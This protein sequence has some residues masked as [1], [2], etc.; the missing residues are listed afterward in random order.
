MGSDL[1]GDVFGDGFPCQ[2]EAPVGIATNEKRTAIMKTQV[3]NPLNRD[4]RSIGRIL[5]RNRDD[6]Q[7]SARQSA[8][9]SSSSHTSVPRGTSCFVR[10]RGSE[11]ILLVG[12]RLEDI[13]KQ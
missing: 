9:D 7:A 1:V 3:G 8:S 5:P 13:K 11:I 4:F 12:S 6:W 10:S 2:A